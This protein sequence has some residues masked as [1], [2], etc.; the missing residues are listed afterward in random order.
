MF[1]AEEP[2]FGVV[3]GDEHAA[4]RPG[5]ARRRHDDKKKTLIKFHLLFLPLNFA[6]RIPNSALERPLVVIYPSAKMQSAITSPIR[7][8]E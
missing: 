2:A 1:C 4:D 8:A 3:F 5:N 7:R 6:F